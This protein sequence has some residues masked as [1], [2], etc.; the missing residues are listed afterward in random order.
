M[1][2]GAD[3]FAEYRRHI[4]RPAVERHLLADEREMTARIDQT[5]N[6]LD[7]LVGGTA[8]N[9]SASKSLLP[10]RPFEK[11]SELRR[12]FEAVLSVRGC[13]FTHHVEHNMARAI[14]QELLNAG[15]LSGS[16]AAN[17]TQD[18]I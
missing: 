3:E 4:T 6:L 15:T 8:G 1:T 11:T 16:F 13:V 12:L 10:Q 2:S 17:A 14:E 7:L 9:I 18:A 5:R